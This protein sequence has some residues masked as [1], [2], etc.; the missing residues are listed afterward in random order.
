MVMVDHGLSKEVIVIPCTK[1]MNTAGIANFFFN[2]IFKWFRLHEQVV[3][4]SRPQFASAF[5]KE[6]ARLLQYKVALSLA[7][8]SQSDGE[9]EHYNQELKTYLCIF[10]EGQPQKWLELL[11]MAKF[12][13]NIAMHSVMSKS[14]FSLI[15]RYEPQSYPPLRRT[16]L[17][18]LEQQ[19]NQIEDT[20]KDTEAAHKL[21]QQCMREQTFFHFKPWK[22]RDK[23]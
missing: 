9:T 21:T 22:V 5:A 17:P 23:V 10:C 11:P 20:W 14:P 12:T 3:S 13:H 8:H 4:D 19:L 15:M 6:L 2:N 7:Y 16:F 18:A 1:M